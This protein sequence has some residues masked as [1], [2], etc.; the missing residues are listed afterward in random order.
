M[1]RFEVVL[2]LALTM[3]IVT[4]TSVPPAPSYTRT[5]L[6]VARSLPGETEEVKVRTSEG[7]LATLIVKRRDHR[8]VQKEE[9]TTGMSTEPERRGQNQSHVIFEVR[10]LQN[11]NGEAQRRLQEN[12]QVAKIRSQVSGP[13]ADQEGPSKFERK[14]LSQVGESLMEYGSWKPLGGGS[15]RA[16][17]EQLQAEEPL[18]TNWKPV[19]TG[20]HRSASFAR[21]SKPNFEHQGMIFAGRNTEK[22]ADRELSFE[23]LN[24][25]RIVGNQEERHGFLPNQPRPVTR[26][27]VGANVYKNRNAK[28]VP[29]E[30]TIRSEINV[31]PASKRSPMTLDADG[32]PTIHGHRVPDDPMDKIQTWRNARVINNKLIPESATVVNLDPSSNFYAIDKTA[33]RQ[34]FENFFDDVNR[35]YGRN[36][37]AEKTN[38]YFEWD[39]KNYQ[40]DA[41]KAEIYNAASDGYNSNVQKRMLH[42]DSVANY[43]NSQSYTPESQKIAPVALKPGV[44][45]PVLQYAHP[46]LGVQ[47]AKIVKNEIRQP[48]SYSEVQPTFTSETRQKKKYVL[49]DKNVVDSYSSKYYYPN[50]RFYGLKPQNDPPFWVKISENLKNQFST[51][52]EKVSQLT[53]PVFDPLVEATQKISKN[54]GLS[55]DVA[56]DKVGTVASGSSILIPALGLVASGAALGIGAVAVGRYLDVD[57]LKRSGDDEI[58]LEHKRA[59]EASA[60]KLPEYGNEAN[61]PDSRVNSESR[62]WQ[63]SFASPNQAANFVQTFE[64][65]PVIVAE[66]EERSQSREDDDGVFLILE[67]SNDSDKVETRETKPVVDELEYVETGRHRRSID[68]PSVL[69]LEPE[70]ADWMRD[71]RFQRKNLDKITEI[72]EIDVPRRG[73]IDVTD[74]QLQRTKKPE[75]QNAGTILVVEGDED[76]SERADLDQGAVEDVAKIVGEMI[77]QSESEE[78]EPQDQK[79]SKRSLGTDQELQDT[80]QNLENAEVAEA[81]HVE[82]DWANTPCAKRI[83]CDAM[84]L[85]G[86][87]AVTFMEKKMASLLA[88]IQPGAANQV[89]SHFEEVMDAIRRHDCSGFLCPQ[90]RPGNV[91]F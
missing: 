71:K 5:M 34:R 67:E 16:L 36:Y 63:A 56:Q 74:L 19:D 31:K 91:F 47:P 89:S 59:L 4:S 57:V 69:R 64:N 45:A 50:H 25:A 80:L 30:V 49:N 9:G 15:E 37:D 65:E 72:V 53:R 32:T 82:G 38:V 22:R 83:F 78:G 66:G 40:N 24:P 85:R 1:P 52:V 51:G 11:Q 21:Y 84:I 14:N 39:P 13:V 62:M 68:D 26:T 46:E 10:K 75:S 41:L 61:E 70:V 87:D 6:K 77:R 23:K 12:E 8:V 81:G 2:V 90:A 33:D 17:E 20:L 79:R 35:R 48:E 54:L 3:V 73:N 60:K 86:S 27:N 18:Y 44:R 7:N 58:D 43:P 29:A 76:A 42:P 88:L 55:R 28:N